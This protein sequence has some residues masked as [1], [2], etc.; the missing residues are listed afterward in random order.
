[1]PQYTRPYKFHYHIHKLLETHYYWK[2]NAS[3]VEQPSSS[4]GEREKQ[5]KN[6]FITS[7]SSLKHKTSTPTL[8][9]QT[10][11]VGQDI[12]FFHKTG[13]LG[14]FK[15]RCFKIIKQV[16]AQSERKLR[17]TLQSFLMLAINQLFLLIFFCFVLF[18]FFV[19]LK[20]FS[21]MVELHG[22][23]LQLV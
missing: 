4:S 16:N 6:N 2:R 20:Y 23:S 13:T 14:Q 19:F 7:T 5:Q 21:F 1:M 18:S 15:I 3:H 8:L 17:R 22:N 10:K 9:S 12:K 11:Q